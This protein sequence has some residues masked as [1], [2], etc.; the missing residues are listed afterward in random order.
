M[1]N[2]INLKSNE[3]LTFSGLKLKVC[4]MGDPENILDV[5]AL[6]PDYLGFIFYENS[7]RNFTGKIP[8]LPSEIKKTGVFVN[9]TPDYIIDKVKEHQFSAIQLHGDETPGF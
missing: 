8:K 2:S 6:M 5:A 4:G 3:K 7:P 9:S 1:E